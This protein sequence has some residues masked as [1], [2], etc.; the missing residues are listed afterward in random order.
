MP[1]IWR[2][3]QILF[4]LSLSKI[5]AEALHSL[6][7]KSSLDHHEYFFSHLILSAASTSLHHA[8]KLFDNSPIVP[9]PLFAWNTLIKA[10]SKT[11]S[12]QIHSV[13]LFLE[14]LRTSDVLK[15]DK[16]TYP[17]VIKACGHCLMLR[18]GESVHSM[19]FKAGFASDLHVNNTLLT[20]YGGCGAV[21]FSR[22]LFDEMCERDVVSWSSMIA[23][24][25][26]CKLDLDALRLFKYMNMVN[27]KPNLVTF[28]SLLAACNNLL[29][30]RIGKSIHSYLL[31]NGT[32]LHVSLGTALLNMYAK[33]GHL[34]EALQIFNTINK[35]NLQ[36]WTVMISC[37]ADYGRGEEAI[38]LFTRMEEAGLRPDSMSFSVVLSAC[39]HR[40][41]LDKGQA[42]FDKMVNVY[43]IIPTMQHYGC[44]VDLFGRAG[45]IEEAYKIIL[46]MP[47]EPNSVII[48]SY[49]SACKH[50]GR[51]LS[52]DK[53]L[54]QL[55]LKTEPNVGANYLLATAISSTSG[56]NG[57][58]NMR[59]AMKLRG[60]KKV[61][62]SSWVHAPG[63]DLEALV[64]TE[65]I[66]KI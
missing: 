9:P 17:F 53:H 8:R 33:S 41:L 49:L 25:V 31:V 23:A 2:Q 55:L 63:G 30:I 52:L 34:E 14:L 61:P 5:S 64:K 51:A 57:M 43:N 48:R 59:N 40:G 3:I 16:F 39:S 13:K 6:L 15:P 1:M 60:L 56:C 35:K 36:S 58:D 28:V 38:S 24:Y 4:Q 27:E 46:S 47:F 42:L 37:L 32:E 19:V 21:E 66:I 65:E 11:S 54:I 10:Y 29:N 45:K 26:D 22:R 7:L 12:A 50:H 20:M 18:V 44:M 62:G